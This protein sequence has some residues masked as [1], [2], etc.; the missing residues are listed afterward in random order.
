MYLKTLEE[1]I[2]STEQMA[3][4]A[5]FYAARW[6]TRVYA[7][8]KSM[9]E[10]LSC[11]TPLFFHGLGFTVKEE[12]SKIELAGKL[13]EDAAKFADS[14]PDEFENIMWQNN[15][16]AITARAAELYPRSRGMG[17]PPGWNCGSL[18]Y[19]PPNAENPRRVSFHIYNTVSPH[20]FF[21]HPDYLILCFLLLMREAELR[22]GAD[23]LFCSSWLNDHP[24]WLEFFPGEWQ[25]NLSPR[26]PDRLTGM[27]V[28]DWGSIYD[29]RGCMN[30][31]HLTMVR[32]SGRLPYSPRK[33]FCSFQAMRRHLAQLNKKMDIYE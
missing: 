1:H 14:T 19:D 18:K 7:P 3:K 30:E 29:A 33:S 4:M 13:L 10:N 12:W 23:T 17:T 22:Y 28:G 15:K 20:S 6:M 26:D 32:E 21:R 5:F 27:T 11:H 31:K 25:E 24:R 8:E 2:F 16:A 9:G